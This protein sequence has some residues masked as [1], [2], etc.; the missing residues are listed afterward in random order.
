MQTLRRLSL[1]PA[2]QLQLAC[3]VYD[4]RINPV[5]DFIWHK[6]DFFAHPPDTAR[7]LD[8]ANRRWI[9]HWTGIWP[10]NGTGTAQGRRSP[11]NRCRGRAVVQAPRNFGTRIVGKGVAASLPHGGKWPNKSAGETSQRGPNCKGR[12]KSLTIGLAKSK[13]GESWKTAHCRD[14]PSNRFRAAQDG[15][16]RAVRVPLHCA[17]MRHRSIREATPASSPPCRGAPMPPIQR[18]VREP[19]KQ[20]AVPRR[21]AG[22]KRG[23][24]QRKP[25]GAS[26]TCWRGEWERNPGGD[27]PTKRESRDRGVLRSCRRAAAG[28][29]PTRTECAPPS[30]QNEVVVEPCSS[31]RHRR[32]QSA[33]AKP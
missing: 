12:K 32:K 25:H 8:Q 20:C 31:A 21:R 27:V 17:S 23:Q 4:A 2:C 24:G 29:S 28:R 16:R 3:S 18:N 13:I 7:A 6:S 26:G 15:F 22:D 19:R 10:P 1:V 9:S 5:N 14:A 30:L 33:K 11:R